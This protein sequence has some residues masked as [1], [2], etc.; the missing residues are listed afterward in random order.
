MKTQFIH[1]TS[2]PHA[3]NAETSDRRFTVFADNINATEVQ[4]RLDW[5]ALR[6][7]ITVDT[8]I[9]EFMP[10]GQ[11]QVA[12][13]ANLGAELVQ[14][15]KAYRPSFVWKSSPAE[16]VGALIEEMAAPAAIAASPVV[17]D[18]WALVPIDPTD[19]MLS[20]IAGTR[21]DRLHPSKQKAERD[22]YTKL[23]LRCAVFASPAAQG[24]AKDAERYRWLTATQGLRYSPP[25]GQAIVDIGEMNAA[26]DAAISAE[27]EAS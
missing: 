20:E 12:A 8:S 24:D 3:M 23:L 19:A 10:T 21:Y 22:A 15:V 9:L 4:E 11:H 5:K 17:P 7:M 6:D 26:I 27:K 18:G 2:S 25:G 16:I 14:E 1:A 13:L